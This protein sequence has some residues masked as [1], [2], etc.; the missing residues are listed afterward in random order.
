M[1]EL[2]GAALDK[3]DMLAEDNRPGVNP[4]NPPVPLSPP[5]PRTDSICIEQNSSFSPLHTDSVGT[6]LGGE[7]ILFLSMMGAQLTLLSL[8]VI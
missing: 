1:P 4:L 6:A 3:L 5:N 2:I 7:H 8:S